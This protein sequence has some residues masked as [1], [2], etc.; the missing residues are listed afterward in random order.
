MGKNEAQQNNLTQEIQNL[1]SLHPTG[2]DVIDWARRYTCQQ[3][4]VKWGYMQ[5]SMLSSNNNEHCL[6]TNQNVILEASFSNKLYIPVDCFY[7]KL[8]LVNMFLDQV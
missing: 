1:N 5:Y 7:L 3:T 4:S 6:N 2:G 8:Q